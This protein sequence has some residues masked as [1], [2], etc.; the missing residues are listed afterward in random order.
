MRPALFTYLGFIRDA[1]RA[2]FVI[3]VPSGVLGPV[4]VIGLIPGVGGL[5]LEAT[6]GLGLIDFKVFGITLAAAPGNIALDTSTPN[7]SFIS[8]IPLRK[9][10]P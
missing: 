1:K 2:L 4:G 5:T 3:G 7:A 6:K 10:G 8:Y 9:E